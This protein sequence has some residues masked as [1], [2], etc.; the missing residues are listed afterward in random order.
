VDNASSILFKEDFS[1][2][3]T[4]DVLNKIS[5][6]N[7]SRWRYKETNEYHIGPIAEDFYALFNVGSD[8]QHLST[9]DPSGVALAGIQELT[10]TVQEQ[11]TFIDKQNE[12]LKKLKEQVETLTKAVQKLSSNK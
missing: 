11:Q 4:K 1:D 7:I 6:L 10:K 5:T 8:Q 3:D 12:E 2:L 9:I